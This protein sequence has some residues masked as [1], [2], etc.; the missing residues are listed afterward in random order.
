MDHVSAQPRM[1]PLRL[2]SVAPDFAAETT[3]YVVVRG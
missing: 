3:Q 1:A 2:G